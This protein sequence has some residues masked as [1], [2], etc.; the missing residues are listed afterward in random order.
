[1]EKFDLENFPTSESAKKMLS[2]VSDGFY[3]ESYVGKWIFQVMG[4]EYDKA[5][6]KVMELPDQFFPET[7]TWGL[8]YHEIKWGLPVRSNLSYEERRRLIYQKR[9]Y[10]A[11]MTPYRMEKYLEDATGFEVHIADASDPGEYGFIPPHPNVFKAYFLGEGTL[12]SKVVFEMLDRL[13]QSHTTYKINDRIEVE[14][15][16]RNLEQI[17]LRNIRFKMG[18]PFWYDYVYDGS[19]LL[20][21][22]VI[23]NT[24]RRY[25]LV[26]GFRFNQ[27]EFYTPEE[28]R[29]ISVRFG[30]AKVKND[31]ALRAR[32]KFHSGINFW[33]V[34][35]FD[36]SWNPDGSLLLDA[37]RRYG[38]SLG[39]CYKFGIASFTEEIK[40]STLGMKWELHSQESI[41]A[42]VILHFAVDFW[43]LLYLNGDWLLDGEQLLSYGR[44]KTKAALTVHSVLNFAEQETMADATVVTKTWDYWFLDGALSFDG[45]R[46]LNSIYRKEAVE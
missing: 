29:L 4:I 39:I 10:R 8:M 16:N 23:L 42:S 27:G 15:D 45:S 3:D 26:L 34:R 38:L 12:D 11:P 24:T 35:C 28:I 44:G 14:L 20:D 13:K 9:D 36:G 31:S 21:G 2:Y 41:A 7:A 30:I 17:I 32:V 43:K 46:S 37:K 33:D 22:S 40:L 25:G 19:W 18:I 5:L 6:E 1:M